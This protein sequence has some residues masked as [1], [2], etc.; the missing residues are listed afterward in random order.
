VFR[1]SPR[2][3]AV[4]DELA[5]KSTWRTL[6][7]IK[8]AYNARNDATQLWA[9]TTDLYLLVEKIDLVLQ[10]HNDPVQDDIV[11]IVGRALEASNRT[12]DELARR[13]VNLGDREDLSLWDRMAGPVRFTLSAESI[14][15]FEQQL[16]TNIMS[17]Q[18]AFLLLG[19]G[20]QQ[21]L[22]RRVNDLLG[23][24]ETAVELIA[25]QTASTLPR[26][27]A[28]NTSE[29]PFP[30][31]DI[32]GDIVEVATNTRAVQNVLTASPLSFASEE[33]ESSDSPLLRLVSQ[34]SEEWG[35]I[36]ERPPRST[37]GINQTRSI[38][39]LA[40][41]DAIRNHSRAD[42]QRLLDEGANTNG[43]DDEGFTPLMYTIKQHETPCNECF[44]CMRMLLDRNVDVNASN[45]GFTTLHMSVK[46]D[47]LEA[48]KALL[49]NGAYIDP[50]IPITPLMLA[51]KSNKVT[52]VE[53][54]LAS[55]PRPDATVVDADGWGLVQHAVWRECKDALLLLLE[56]N[57]MMELNLDIDA[58]CAMDRTP[59]MR[60]A[61]HAEQSKSVKLATILL[62]YGA[63]VNAVDACSRSA[64]HYAITE[65]PAKTQRNDFV[66][67][68][69]DRRAEIG[70]V[71]SKAPKRFDQFPALKRKADMSRRDSAHSASDRPPVSRRGG[72]FSAFW[73]RV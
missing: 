67:L 39:S 46:K 6:E 64:L 3:R 69:L 37:A 28:L 35:R 60:L 71:R 43:T 61:E 29:P 19:R 9:R 10:E 17:V 25:Q 36:A 50:S 38:S 73:S 27:D 15:R 14:Q 59:L 30:A 66:Q 1:I 55:D 5:V 44:R 48:A 62:D 12:L 47:N 58:R 63:D 16:Q 54:F 32:L 57:K 49:E 42:F 23:V 68:L 18:I 21:E 65:G 72:S 53:L 11:T 41:I 13:C 7:L 22:T 70:T 56:S 34:E 8:S 24:L 26:Q 2:S 31:L 20:E 40:L 52:F 4:I 51:V 33:G 45:N